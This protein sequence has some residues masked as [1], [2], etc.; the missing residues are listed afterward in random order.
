MTCA[1]V[2][3]PLFQRATWFAAPYDPD[4]SVKIGYVGDDWDTRAFSPIIECE[5][6]VSCAG[7]RRWIV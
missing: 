7:D 6:V 4:G 1:R 3:L 5:R 2:A